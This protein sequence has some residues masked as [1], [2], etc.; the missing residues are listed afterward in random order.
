MK[1]TPLAFA[2]TLG[3][4]A[5]M[6]TA[7]AHAS[8]P[9]DRFPLSVADLE[10]RQAAVFSAVDSDGDGRISAAEFAAHEP[11]A[12]DRESGGDTDAERGHHRRWKSRHDGAF[13]PE[14]LDPQ[15]MDGRIFAALDGNGDGNLTPDEFTR[16]A[17]GSA[18]QTVMKEVMFARLDADGDGFLSAGEFPPGPGASLDTDGDGQITREEMRKRRHSPEAG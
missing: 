4:V 9:A 7:L 8:P 15:E 18:R 5:I 6:T 12:G 11:R 1:H 16:E 2:I 17:L 14:A 3:G 10:A 13:R